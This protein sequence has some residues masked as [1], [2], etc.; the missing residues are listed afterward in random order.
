MIIIT[1][2]Y[3]L[4]SHKFEKALRYSEL[5]LWDDSIISLQQ[6]INSVKSESHDFSDN[7]SFQND[8]KNIIGKLEKQMELYLS[9]KEAM[10]NNEWREKL[11]IDL[12]LDYMHLEGLEAGTIFGGEDPQI[13]KNRI[14]KNEYLLHND[15]E[16]MIEGYTMTA[17]NFIRTSFADIVP[18]LSIIFILLLSSDIVSNEIEGG[19]YKL[20]LTQPISRYKIIFSKIIANSSI[21]ILTIGF[22][23]MVFFIG[24]GIIKGFG[25]PDYPVQY[26]RA[27]K[28]NALTLAD[29]DFGGFIDIKTFVIYTLLFA[30]LLITMIVAVAILVSTI[31]NNS[32]GAISLSIILYLTFYIFISQLQVAKKIIHLIPF[33]YSNIPKLLSGSMIATYGN[34]NITYINGIIVL[35]L[36]TLFCYVLTC[37]IF[38]KKDIH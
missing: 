24:L 5:A 21:C 17:Y 6:G 26:Y 36:T 2:L 22:I 18:L 15:I 32:A 3:I 28:V 8:R 31:I 33:I 37:L 16:P 7:V 34:S 4:L 11:R 13:I 23:N 10:E 14:S 30:I 29:T 25:D 27:N 1:L 20:L 9:K 35:F 38:K 19:S 12:I